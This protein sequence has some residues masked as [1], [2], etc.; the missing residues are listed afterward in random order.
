LTC[1]S[2]NNH[3]CFFYKLGLGEIMARTALKS[4]APKSS[5]EPTQQAL[6]SAQTRARLIESTIRCL[7]KFGYSGTTTPK[8][9]AEAGLSRGAM[10]HHFENGGALM[11]ATI[12]ELLDRR[13]RAFRRAAA[14]PGSD[15]RTLVRTYWKQLLSP[16]FVAF[17]ELAIAARTDNNLAR[18]LEPAQAEFRE[19]WYELAVQLFPQWQQ[20]RKAF[21]LALALT[22]NTVEGMAINRLIHGCDE[23]MIDPVLDNL[24][25]QIIALRPQD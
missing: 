2:K 20:D 1:Q 12:A 25:A 19:R 13:L 7:V 18:I 3:A 17:V 5:F 10:L 8:V 15:V 4:S 23:A 14:S 24:E 16:T 22:Q 6:K 21:D 9:A 11:Q